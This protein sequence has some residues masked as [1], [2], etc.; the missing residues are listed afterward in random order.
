[1]RSSEAMAFVKSEWTFAVSEPF[2]E[3]REKSRSREKKKSFAKLFF[4][5][6]QRPFML[7]IV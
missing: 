1:M 7:F 3:V 4:E 5:M 6:L 2:G